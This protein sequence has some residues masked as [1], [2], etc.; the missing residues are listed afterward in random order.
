MN[1]SGSAKHTPSK[2]CRFSLYETRWC[3]DGAATLM[4][5]VFKL[6]ARSAVLAITCKRKANCPLRTFGPLSQFTVRVHLGAELHTAEVPVHRVCRGKQNH[7]TPRHAAKHWPPTQILALLHT[8]SRTP[9]KLR[10]S[11]HHHC[12]SQCGTVSASKPRHALLTIILS[13][14]S[15]YSRVAKTTS[16]TQ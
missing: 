4:S 10:H 7:L 11:I 9:S 3:L 14:R 13:A 1:E 6:V 8:A 15:I 16:C 12:E 2:G 5:V